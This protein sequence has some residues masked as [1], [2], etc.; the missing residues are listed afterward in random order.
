MVRIILPCFSIEAHG[1]IIPGVIFATN[2]TG[3]YVKF[4]IPRKRTATE[5]Q[6]KV[7]HAYGEVATQWRYLTTEQKQT[8]HIKAV[9]NRWTDYNQYFHEI[10]PIIYLLWSTAIL[11]AGATGRAHLGRSAM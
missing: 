8:Y 6:A 7:R 5:A 4:V 11:G 3:Q 2:K 9:K 1:A 10:W